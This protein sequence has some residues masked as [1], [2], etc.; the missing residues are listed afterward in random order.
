V[1][2]LKI[3]GIIV[4]YNPLHNGHLYHLEQVKKM[5]DCDL[6]IAVMSGDF[7]QRGQPSLVNK[8]LRTK[9]AL[10]AGVDIVIEL[11]YL[12]AVS[13]ADLFSLGAISLL[14]QCGVNEIVF[15]SETNEVHKLEEIARL[16][17]HPHFNDLIKINLNN[18]FSYPEASSIALSTLTQKK[19]E[20]LSNDLL[21]IQYIRNI[22]RI[23]KNITFRSI[24]RIHTN[25]KD[26]LITHQNIASATSI[27]EAITNQQEFKK[28]IPHYTL[29]VI[30]NAKLHDWN[31]YF[32]Y[33]KYEI[34]T[35][36]N[37]LQE[38]HDVNEGLEN[39]LIKNIRNSQNFKHFVN[40][41][42][43]KRYTT[44]KIQRTL[45][46]VL[47]HVTK[48]EVIKSD[49]LNGPKFIRILGFNESKSAFIKQI[50]KSS[51]IP[52][53]TNI[54]KSNIDLLKLDLRVSEVYHLID[55]V[56]ERK[57]PCILRHK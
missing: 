43:S 1:R 55:D 22:L 44:A 41:L 3:Y 32:S 39:A 52:L 6:L 38:I 36:K 23:N 50:Q 19:V 33:L 27:R 15:G 10:Q 9:L 47:N 35:N 40:L 26:T 5:N 57:I 24:K 34:T 28:T 12:Y 31:H 4:E 8:Q 11:P 29:D 21:G 45:T 51:Q 13:H 54:N 42:V 18:G 49:I 20:L 25:Y 2:N 17:D 56:K 30:E 37:N 16:I 14:N 46:H 48:E 53:I 7:V